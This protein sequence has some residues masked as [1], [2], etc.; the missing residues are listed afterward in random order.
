MTTD[1]G[2]FM[3][4]DTLL[5]FGVG[6]GDHHLITVPEAEIGYLRYGD[7]SGHINWARS[8]IPLTR[9]DGAN[10]VCDFTRT[11]EGVTVPRAS[12]QQTNLVAL[13]TV[14]HVD[15][16]TQVRT[17]QLER[18]YFLP[19]TDTGHTGRYGEFTAFEDKSSG[20]EALYDN[21]AQTD[22]L[23]KLLTVNTHGLYKAKELFAHAVKEYRTAKQAVEAPSIRQRTISLATREG[24]AEEKLAAIDV[25]HSKFKLVQLAFDEEL[26][27]RLAHSAT[28]DRTAF[29]SAR[30]ASSNANL[31]SAFQSVAPFLPVKDTGDDPIRIHEKYARNLYASYK[32]TK[33]FFVN[34]GRHAQDGTKLSLLY[35]ITRALQAAFKDAPGVKGDISR[36]EGLAATTAAAVRAGDA[37]DKFGDYLADLEH[38]RD[39]TEVECLG[40]FERYYPDA[41]MLRL[42]SDFLKRVPQHLKEFVQTF[43]KYKL[44][45]ITEDKVLH[46]IK[47]KFE[48]FRKWLTSTS[49]RSREMQHT[50]LEKVAKRAGE[51]FSFGGS[52]GFTGTMYVKTVLS[53]SD[54]LLQG[55][56]LRE[57]KAEC[58]SV[59][60][61]NICL[62]LQGITQSLDKYSDIVELE[63]AVTHYN[64]VETQNLFADMEGE[65]Q[66]LKGFNRY[67]DGNAARHLIGTVAYS[68]DSQYKKA[69]NVRDKIYADR[70]KYTRMYFEKKLE[71]LYVE[72]SDIR[73]LAHYQDIMG[74]IN[75]E[76]AQICEF[77]AGPDQRSG[78][79]RLLRGTEGTLRDTSDEVG[80]FP[81]MKTLF[82][83][84]ISAGRLFIRARVDALAKQIHAQSRPTGT[85]NTG[86]RVYDQD[87]MLKLDQHRVALQQVTDA[88]ESTIDARSQAFYEA[89]LVQRTALATLQEEQQEYDFLVIDTG[90]RLKSSAPHRKR[91]TAFTAALQGRVAAIDT[92][93][94]HLA[95]DLETEIA[96]INTTIVD[97]PSDGGTNAQGANCQIDAI[98]TIR[99]AIV[100]MELKMEKHIVGHGQYPAEIYED[101]A[102]LKDAFKEKADL[103]AGVNGIANTSAP[104]TVPARLVNPL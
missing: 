34:E 67:Y 5:S 59:N 96:R 57:A 95:Y 92:E 53:P 69:I 26:T 101:I 16:D 85:F 33:A 55:D 98:T 30:N 29:D 3:Q 42:P 86:P 68:I 44:K 2:R 32:A 62:E 75:D 61:N 64:T 79:N 60:V 15:P 56:Y 1:Y 78:L 66:E 41:T 22:Y 70:V 13:R 97:I 43:W 19:E 45:Q 37:P 51:Q 82:A 99:K 50:S 38:T 28:S 20:L 65:F 71:T 76:H 25:A 40:L 91:N 23:N 63:D 35:D 103:V 47:G 81:T 24:I 10:A 87:R 90:N 102:T 54:S 9:K 89:G 14:V 80:K 12:I 11:D 48:K 52:R 58:A 27:K 39:Y 93:L 84:R 49:I 94:G 46:L 17:V 4:G 73:D 100:D 74:K 6:D 36:A 88:D 77:F 8:F 7:T 31:D 18:K 21:P 104:Y 83:N 72:L